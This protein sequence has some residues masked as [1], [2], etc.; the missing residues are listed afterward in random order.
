MES[1]QQRYH[2]EKQ[3]LSTA[4]GIL[5][6]GK[7]LSLQRQ[8]FL[9]QIQ[10]N[11]QTTKEET[12]RLLGSVAHFA[13]PLF[14]HILDLDEG[15]DGVYAVLEYRSGDSLL[16]VLNSRSFPLSF[17]EALHLIMGLGETLQD[18]LEERVR[19]FSV[20]A[21]NIWLDRDQLMVINY[22]AEG[23]IQQR[24]VLGLVH[25]FY[26]LL[27][28]TTDLPADSDS[29]EKEISLSM[30]PYFPEKKEKFAK[31]IRRVLKGHESLSAFLLE[32]QS[33]EKEDI[34]LTH[35][36]EDQPV[37]DSPIETI[38]EVIDKVPKRRPFSKRMAIASGFLLLIILGYVSYVQLRSNPSTAPASLPAETP[39]PVKANET[40]ATPP[41][42]IEI[43]A[44]PLPSS[45]NMILIPDLYGL[46]KE[47]AE[48]LALANGLHY[49]YFVEHNELQEGLVFKQEPESGT[50]VSKGGYI[51]FWISKGAASQ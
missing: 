30:E 33:L 26:Q 40:V 20:T 1:I 38:P 51:T 12:K 50:E 21:E 41:S 42:P 8:V 3:V 5:H 37:N 6:E 11:R 17:P 32:L 35:N 39:K 45:D 43:E 44:T 31:L 10:S 47:E 34:T 9:Y 13:N 2:F 36:E 14:F 29:I 23:D 49:K 18:A 22:W 48:K 25:L 46:S 19:G 24:G 16:H 4:N 15:K 7:D 28:Q 27:Y